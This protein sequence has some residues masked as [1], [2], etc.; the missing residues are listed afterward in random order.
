MAA[1]SPALLTQRQHREKKRASA[2]PSECS[3][4]S[5]RSTTCATS[6]PPLRHRSTRTLNPLADAPP[7]QA[8]PISITY[9]T[10]ATAHR[11]VAAMLQGCTF[12]THSLYIALIP[13]QLRKS[14]VMGR[15]TRFGVPSSVAAHSAA[16][17]SA[18]ASLSARASARHFR[19]IRSIRVLHCCTP[20]KKTKGRAGLTTVSPLNQL[21]LECL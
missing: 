9:T 16:P 17:P 19:S 3:E 15:S 7:H 5:D 6:S 1:I 13:A 10:R 4:I 20:P 11:C 12:G 21:Q 18:V 2:S 8:S 14:G